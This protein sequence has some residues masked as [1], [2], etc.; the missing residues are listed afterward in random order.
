MDTITFIPENQKKSSS[1]VVSKP[2]DI[3]K[4]IILRF[5]LF[6]LIYFIA[7]IVIYFV[8][9]VGQRSKLTAEIKDVDTIGS[10]YYPKGDFV[11][12]FFN[13]NDVITKSLDPSESIR[14][15][16][17][18]YIPNSRVNSI[19]YD[20][21]KKTINLSMVV[22]YINDVSTQVKAFADINIVSKVDF[23]STST[24]QDNSG[25][26]FEAIIVLK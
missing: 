2:K 4:F 20:K 11:Q 6:L 10:T 16:E 17:S 23:T 14:Q 15:I 8:V 7:I 3:Y 5:S 25:V 9:V 24:L 21:T 19:I 18:A 26:L 13:I 22:P 1:Y 12:S